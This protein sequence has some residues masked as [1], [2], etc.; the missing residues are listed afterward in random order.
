MFQVECVTLD[1]DSDEEEVVEVNENPLRTLNGIQYRASEFNYL[2][3]PEEYLCD[4]V[5]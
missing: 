3:D 4:K 1:G 5:S 2:L